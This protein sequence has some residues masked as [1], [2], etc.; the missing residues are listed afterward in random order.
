MFSGSGRWIGNNRGSWG[1]GASANWTDTNGSG[2]R[3]APGTWG[4]NDTAVLSET[5][6]SGASITLDGALPTLAGLI[7]SSI[8]GGFTLAQGSGGTLNLSNGSNTAVVTSPAV[9]S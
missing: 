6:G 9:R 3:A 1:S 5:G 4:Y 8:G 2:V 7:F